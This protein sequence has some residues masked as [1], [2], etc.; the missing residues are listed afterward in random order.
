MEV[1]G[2]R[3]RLVLALALALALLGGAAPAFAQQAAPKEALA[4]LTVNLRAGP[5]TDADIVGEVAQDE[6]FPILDRV[7]GEAVEAGNPIWFQTE[8]GFVYSGGAAPLFERSPLSTGLTGRWIEVD[9]A[10]QVARAVEDGAVVHTALVTVGR[11]GFPT[12]VGVFHILRRV[13]NETMDSRTIGIPL[14][15][16][17]GYF[18]TGVLF[19]QYL[20]DDGVALHFNYWS[21]PEA[22]GNLPESRGC[23]GLRLPDAEFFW[24][25]AQLGTPVIITS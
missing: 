18:L 9:R 19:T 7:S 13:E 3:A 11:A 5:S 15:S 14:D 20:T 4:K 24:N 17:Q 6:S 1:G 8:G 12:P 21:P 22:F 23:I 10:E 16:P 2:V 25:F